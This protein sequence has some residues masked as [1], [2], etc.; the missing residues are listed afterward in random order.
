VLDHK[1]MNIDV[2]LYILSELLNI[3]FHTHKYKS[4]TL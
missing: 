4:I 3:I 1:I 2:I